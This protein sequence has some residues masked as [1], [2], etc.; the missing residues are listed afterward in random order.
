MADSCTWRTPLNCLPGA[1]KDGIEGAK[2]NLANAP[3]RITDAAANSALDSLA[4][5]VR[6]GMAWVIKSTLSWWINTDS[7][8]EGSETTIE[9]IRDLVLP[10]VVVVAI[11]GIVTQGVRMIVQRKGEPLIDVCRGL[12]FIVLWMAIGAAGPVAMVEA[13]DIFST[14][15]LEASTDGQFAKKFDEAL[16]MGSIPVAIVVVL[17]GVVAILAASVQAMIML[18][19]EGAILALSGVLVLAAA[20][21]MMTVTSGWQKKV[22][23]WLLALIWYKPAAALIYSVGFLLIKNAKDNDPRT[24]YVGFSMLVLSL[25]ALPAMQ[26]LFTWGVGNLESRGTGLGVG[27][28]G[29]TAVIHAS[30]ALAGAASGAVDH[31]RFL[32]QSL[33][34]APAGFA[35]SHNSAASS[36]APAVAPSGGTSMNAPSPLRMAEARADGGGQGSRAAHSPP[37]MTPAGTSVPPGRPEPPRRIERGSA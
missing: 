37:P 1:V 3:G 35:S 10:L 23:G 5:S 27:I 26:K 15:V 24:A 9:N 25:V 2:D 16:G 30:T 6:D 19:R 31:S 36:P 22:I 4:E 32:S 20:G 28:A 33:G 11:A 34:S 21:S 29:G 17:L 7:L 13:S 14:E 18:L 8:S 12:G